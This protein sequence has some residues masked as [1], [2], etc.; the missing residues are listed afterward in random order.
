LSWARGVG[1]ADPGDG[2]F[3]TSALTAVRSDANRQFRYRGERTGKPGRL[4]TYAGKVNWQAL[5]RFA[6]VEALE[7]EAD[8]AVESD[9]A[10]LYHATLKRWLR[11]VVLVWYT[12]AGKRQHA[13]W[14]TTDLQ[15]T[16]AEVLRI[17]QARFQIEFLLRD[18][19]QH[20]GL[21]PCQARN[22]EALDL[23]LNASLARGSAATAARTN[24]TPYVFSLATQNNRL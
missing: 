21:S 3:Q 18:G 6:K 11:T 24:E 22:K 13:L 19:K 15:A 14:A 17:Y 16:A 20:A 4:K 9:T 10:E 5:S 8:Q 2:W 1:G 7:L 12:V 23:H